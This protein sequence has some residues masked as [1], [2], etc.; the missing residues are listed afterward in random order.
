MAK[1]RSR[2][3]VGALIQ[4]RFSTEGAYP[5]ARTGIILDGEGDFF[6]I[7][8]H[9]DRFS[10]Y[11][12]RSEFRLIDSQPHGPFVFMRDALP[13]GLWTTAEGR[14]VLFSRDYR[15]IWSRMPGQSAVAADPEERIRFVREEWIYT[16]HRP[17]WR[18]KARLRE[19]LQALR[20]WG[21]PVPVLTGLKPKTL[22]I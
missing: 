15:P 2:A 5:E 3:G 6:Q 12:Q 17:P 22:G 18:N 16:G 10:V 8:T 4:M 19:C 13:Y 9:S 14:E 1:N 21:A 7:R 11:A 20:D